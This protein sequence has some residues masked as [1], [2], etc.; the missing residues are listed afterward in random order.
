MDNLL[1]IYSNFR[2]GFK[3][4]PDY[5]IEFYSRHSIFLSNI[6]AFKDKEDLRL[7]I[8]LTWQYL[9]AIFRKDRFN[10]TID[11]ADK[12]LGL[13]NDEIIRLNAEELK[14]I[15]YNGIL[16]LK[17]MASYNVRDYKNASLIFRQL[18]TTDDKNDNFKKWLRFS[19]HGE[20][21]WLVQ[22]TN[23]I[24]GI[25][26]LIAILLRDQI[27]IL[28]RFPILFIGVVG[29]T[30]NLVYEYFLNKSFRKKSS[31]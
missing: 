26:I 13:I 21:L 7:F 31:S 16:F 28:I 1:K 20:R 10:E 4:S 5:V 18:V 22:T 8:E 15:W 3:D 6:K 19:S 30:F 11:N 9:N 12:S 25:A 2:S 14:D 23:I 24:C 27:H 17:G 29:L